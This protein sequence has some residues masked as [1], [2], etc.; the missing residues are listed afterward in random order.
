[1]ETNHKDLYEAPTIQVVELKF[2]RF[3]CESSGAGVQNYN[4][5]NIPM[6]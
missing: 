1:M 2:E 3:I 5:N 4:W 6:E